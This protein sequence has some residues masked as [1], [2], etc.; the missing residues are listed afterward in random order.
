MHGKMVE[1][2]H[3]FL[4]IELKPGVDDDDHK[5]HFPAIFHHE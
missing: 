1:L 2:V 4:G 5:L 3:K